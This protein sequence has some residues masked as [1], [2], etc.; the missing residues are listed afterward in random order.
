[1]S[2]SK[3]QV[4][5]NRI[6]GQ[7]SHGPKDTTLTRFNSKKHGLLCAGITELDDAERYYTLLDNLKREIQPVGVVE[8]LLVESAAMDMLR[9][10]RARR[11]EAEFINGELHPPLEVNVSKSL[12]LSQPIIVEL[13]EPA[14][15]SSKSAQPLVNVFQRYEST[16][17]YRLFR[18]LHELERL[19]R[20][21]QGERLPAPITVDVDVHASKSS[22]PEDLGESADTKIMDPIADASARPKTLS[23]AINCD[24]H[25]D[26]GVLDSVPAASKQP[27]DVSGDEGSGPIAKRTQ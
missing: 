9:W 18:T 21:R 7:K 25:S 11:L 19:Q 26:A 1:M 6:N 20:M 22:L 27:K 13:G 10:P 8:T 14:A 3:R 2:T 5:A 15:I 16:F 4:A 17:A 23:G 12:G 24:V